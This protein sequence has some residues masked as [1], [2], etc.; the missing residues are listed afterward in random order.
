MERLVVAWFGCLCGNTTQTPSDD[1]LRG[2]W[3]HQLV[4][5]LLPL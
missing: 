3:T 5:S 2:L 1:D 4:P